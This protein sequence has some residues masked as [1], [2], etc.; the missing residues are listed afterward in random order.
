MIIM[1]AVIERVRAAMK[2]KPV[3][4]KYVCI[5]NLGPDSTVYTLSFASL[6]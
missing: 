6:I 2:M 3:D 1:D 5:K 4:Q